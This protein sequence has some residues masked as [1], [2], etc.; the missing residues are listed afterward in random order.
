[1]SLLGVACQIADASRVPSLVVSVEMV[2][3][4]FSHDSILSHPRSAGLKLMKRLQRNRNPARLEVRIWFEF[5]PG[6]LL[7]E[8]GRVP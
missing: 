3:E 1:M 7:W 8:L 6:P 5:V 4:P 2:I